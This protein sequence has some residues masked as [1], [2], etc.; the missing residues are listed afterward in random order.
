M[1]INP[2]SNKIQI[3]PNNNNNQ[4]LPESPNSLV[5]SVFN[6]CKEE[7]KSCN[8]STETSVEDIDYAY[9]ND[10]RVPYSNPALEN[11]DLNGFLESPISF[12]R[13]IKELEQETKFEL[14][15]LDS[16][17][18]GTDLSFEIPNSNEFG[19]NEDEMNE[20]L[21][22]IYIPSLNSSEGSEEG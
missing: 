13:D 11:F 14:M 20:L 19:Y 5:Q 18:F 7:N 10:E 12:R 1:S 8:S 2:V 3:N 22:D 17:L 21:N 6:A 4:D 9:F 16:S 15:P